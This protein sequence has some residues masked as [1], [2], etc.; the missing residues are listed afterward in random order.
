MACNCLVVD[1]VKRG[2]GAARGGVLD[3][4]AASSALDCQ[5]GKMSKQE[6]RSTPTPDGISSKTL[7]YLLKEKLDEV[8]VTEAMDELQQILGISD[9]GGKS[10]H[11][12]LLLFLGCIAEW[13]QMHDYH[14]ALSFY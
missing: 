8:E 13:H 12:L 1:G 5:H 11:D 6:Q 10:Q 3:V 2:G 7:L 9:L 14:M 4:W